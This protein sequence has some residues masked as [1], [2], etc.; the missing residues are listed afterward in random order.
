MDF[1]KIFTKV[2]SKSPRR[3]KVNISQ[4]FSL[5]ELAEL[6]YTDL[7]I[8]F[9][10]LHN[11]KISTSQDIKGALSNQTI[12]LTFEECSFMI[13]T[14]GLFIKSRNKLIDKGLLIPSD[15]RGYY[16]FNPFVFN[17]CTSV[18]NHILG[19]INLDK[20]KSNE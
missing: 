18:Q 14:K 8:M 16:Y 11:D 10:I 19:I 9:Y 20:F 5:D 6:S 7:R 2:F 3:Y 17:K 4:V 1:L 15:R 12:K 13:P